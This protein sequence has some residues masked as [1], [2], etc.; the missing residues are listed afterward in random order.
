MKKLLV[1]IGIIAVSMMMMTGCSG[2]KTIKIGAILPL[3]G[4]LASIGKDIQCAIKIGVKHLNAQGGIRN[5]PVQVFF[6]DSLGL[7]DKGKAAYIRLVKEKGVHVIVG[8]VSSE[9]TLALAP[10]AKKYEVPIIS[11]TSSSPKLTK[12]GNDYTFRVYPSD[13]IE[14]RRLSDTM[15]T[16]LFIR[17]FVPIAIKNE[18]GYGISNEVIRIARST[19]AM[20][21]PEVIRYS[22]DS[23]Y[24]D[25]LAIAE[26]VK[27]LAPEA[28]LIAG[29]PEDSAEL[30]KA[31]HEVKAKCYIFMTSSGSRQ[32]SLKSTGEAAL[33]V[34]YAKAPFNPKATD[35][36]TRKFVQDYVD[37]CGKVPGVYA[38]HGYDAIT[39]AA[40]SF[41]KS[42]RPDDILRRLQQ[43][44]QFKGV[45]GDITFDRY[46]DV[47]Q[48][49]KIFRVRSIEPD[50]SLKCTLLTDED[51]A[52]IK[53]SILNVK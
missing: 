41:S 7:P 10:L 34:I 52:E 18:Y 28:V 48:Y 15:F 32:D 6:E 36:K 50:G 24:E 2:E 51:K 45:S 35:E 23:T 3:S 20:N 31:L 26:K 22:P 40:K 47:V 21:I 4:P 33:G 39:I 14:A 46:G 11:P 37:I 27:A 17:K 29:Y 53:D 8:A 42:S 9:V 16:Q 13:T 30:L 49:P 44:K 43:V 19:Q 25:F 5:K 12:E 1:F 38:A